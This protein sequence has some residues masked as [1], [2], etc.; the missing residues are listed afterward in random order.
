MQTD[1]CAESRAK[2]F[3]VD[4]Y[5]KQQYNNKQQWGIAPR[6]QQG[7]ERQRKRETIFILMRRPEILDGGFSKIQGDRKTTATA[8]S[9]LRRGAETTTVVASHGYERSLSSIEQ[10]KLVFEPPLFGPKKKNGWLSAFIPLG[11]I[12]LP[13]QRGERAVNG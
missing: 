12:L 5:S 6:I 9:I 4:S 8:I 13:L 2:P 10:I 3:R 1:A 11:L 7:R